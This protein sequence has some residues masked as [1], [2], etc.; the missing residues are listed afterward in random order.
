MG[1]FGNDARSEAIDTASHGKEV[2]QLEASNGELDETYRI[3]FFQT[4]FS[5][6]FLT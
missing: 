4:L 5:S 2:R 3:C 6:C 1:R